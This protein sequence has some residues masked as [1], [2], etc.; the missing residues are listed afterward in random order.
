MCIV[1]HDRFLVGADIVDT[2]TRP[3]GV[4]SFREYVEMFSQQ[5]TPTEVNLIFR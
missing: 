1:S 2:I 5:L 3:N 4:E